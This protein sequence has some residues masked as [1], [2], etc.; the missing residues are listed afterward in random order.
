MVLILCALKTFLM[1]LV[2]SE[3]VHGLNGFAAAYLDDLVTFSNSR[4]EHLQ[5]LQQGLQCLTEAGLL[6]NVSRLATTKDV[7][8]GI[9]RLALDKVEAAQAFAVP[10]TIT[11]VRAFLGLTGCYRKF[12][13]NY[14][15]I[16]FPLTD[17]TKKTG[18]NQVCWYSHC[19]TAFNKLK[20][21]L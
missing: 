15:T 11:D 14:A 17:L 7:G 5:H 13:P 3:I 20:A 10:Q 18:P 21:L 8:N 2:T 6:G 19:E 12:I 1:L 9:V 16:A 4:Q